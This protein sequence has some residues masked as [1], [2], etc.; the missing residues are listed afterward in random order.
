MIAFKPNFITATIRSIGRFLFDDEGRHASTRPQVDPPATAAD[1]ALQS[2]VGQLEASLALLRSETAV[3]FPERSRRRLPGLA[4]Q[5]LS[6]IDSAWRSRT[7]CRALLLQAVARTG[8]SIWLAACR[9]R[10][11]QAHG[12]LAMRRILWL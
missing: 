12:A 6:N 10:V 9:H 3:A 11:S 8:L 7:R 2:R 4:R 5:K 1:G